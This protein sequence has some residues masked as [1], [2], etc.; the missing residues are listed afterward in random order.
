MFRHEA[1]VDVGPAACFSVM[2]LLLF[3]HFRLRT[4]FKA[5]DHEAGKFNPGPASLLVVAVSVPLFLHLLGLLGEPRTGKDFT[6]RQ[7]DVLA[8]CRA[9]PGLHRPTLA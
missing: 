4:A 2:S 1:C 7:T 5:W 6:L 8:R 9:A 3:S